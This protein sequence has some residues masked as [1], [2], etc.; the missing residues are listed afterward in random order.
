MDPTGRTRAAAYREAPA[1]CPACAEVMRHE[2]TTSGEVEACDACEGL[3]ID[4]FDGDENAVAVEAEAARL[5]RGTP[6]PSRPKAPTSGSRTCPR[7]SRAL[8]P[9]LYRFRDA[10]DD[11]LVTGVELLRC[12]ECAG[13]FVPRG[14]AHLLLDREREAKTQSPWQ[15]LASLLRRV[16][17][18]D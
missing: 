18:R 1:R 4:W 13:A 14:S 8:V 6:P 10:T 5:D 12:A 2:I 11:E 15:A 3:W 16:F 7:C 17:D 9:E